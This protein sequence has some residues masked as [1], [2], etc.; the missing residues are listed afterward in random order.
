MKKVALFM[1]LFCTPAACMGGFQDWIC[2][3]LLR[4]HIVRQ[5]SAPTET[6][7][8]LSNPKLQSISKPYNGTVKIPIY[9]TDKNGRETTNYIRMDITLYWLLISNGL[10]HPRDVS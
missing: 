10:F 4:E 1:I 2:R 6:D 3:H 5:P 7:P 8:L 9:E